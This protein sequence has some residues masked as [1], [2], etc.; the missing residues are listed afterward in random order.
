VQTRLS[1]F[2]AC[3]ELGLRRKFKGNPGHLIIREQEDPGHGGDAAPRNFLIL[4]D[5]VPGGTGYLKEFVNSPDQ[6]RS[7]LEEAFKTL[8]SCPCRQQE[9]TDGCYRCLY[10][11]QHQYELEFV[12]REMGIKLLEAILK[13]WDGVRPVQTL[14]NIDLSDEFIESELEGRFLATMG[15][16]FGKPEHAWSKV[17]K[18]GKACYEFVL[19][20]RKWTIE[21]QVLLT[22][23][24]GVA[25]A[26]KPD[27]VLWPDKEESGI[28]PVAVFTDGFAYHVRPGDPHG[29]ISDDIE[30]RIAIIRS[31]R[32]V[33][34]SLTWDDLQQ[35]EKDPKAEGLNI[36]TELAP[37]TNKIRQILTKAGC[38][39]DEALVIGSSMACLLAYLKSP[40]M[41][42]WGRGI[43]ASVLGAMMPVPPLYDM[44]SV[45]EYAQKIRNDQ[46]LSL[47]ELTP[48][49][50]G[51]NCLAKLYRSQWL[52]TLMAS[53]REQVDRFDWKH[54]TT[55]LWLEDG[56]DQRSSDGYKIL[57]RKTLASANLLQ[58]LPAFEWFSTGLV[59]DKTKTKSASGPE[60][61]VDADTG[62]EDSVE[63][64]IALC[65]ESCRGLLRLCVE[66]GKLLPIVGYELAGKDGGVCAEAELAWPDLKIAVLVESQ[67]EF[68]DLFE[69][70]GWKLFRATELT[71]IG[72][73]ILEQIQG[74]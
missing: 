27:F 47:S 15:K 14:T 8:K 29:R 54:I 72:V 34:W 39:F 46:I 56:L 3:L 38:N 70:E 40:I 11:Y 9:E 1:T 4:Y 61:D 19:E 23:A 52:T 64:L 49:E 74:V 60:E 71:E 25:V 66:Q 36:F 68:R 63:E 12:S 2:K 30:K 10:A 69:S 32:F 58:F 21:P 22:E 67:D 26:S 35:F 62:H 43:A 17:L 65:D 45:E 5:S 24:D 6:F 73:S 53:E 42:D 31:R 59:V 57:W 55:I 48:V 33:V 18:G 37:E 20:K 51:G 13:G 7:L 41:Q 28:L 16:Y 44:E 50:D